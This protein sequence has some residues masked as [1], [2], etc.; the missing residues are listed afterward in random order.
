MSLNTIIKNRYFITAAATLIGGFIG[1]TI[2]KKISK[3]ENAKELADI[4]ENEETNISKLNDELKISEIR[5][6]AR[7]AETDAWIDNCHWLLQEFAQY[8]SDTEELLNNG[9]SNYSKFLLGVA[10]DIEEKYIN[11]HRH[12]RYA[13]L[14]SDVPSIPS[15]IDNWM[16]EQENLADDS[17]VDEANDD[18]PLDDDEDDVHLVKVMDDAAVKNIIAEN[19]YDKESNKKPKLIKG[20]EY[21]EIFTYTQNTLYF[22]RDDGVLATDDDE[23]IEDPEEILGD[24]LDKYGFRDN[25][26]PAIYVRNYKLETDFEVLKMND[27]YKNAVLGG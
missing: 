16:D 11:N 27:S 3:K 12:N 15:I 14:N 20:E 9:D 4:S 8:V 19:G 21:G 13:Y 6:C 17:L 26:E 23:I 1:F 7:E 2:C 24:A 18:H 25:T 10:D 22:Y 5:R